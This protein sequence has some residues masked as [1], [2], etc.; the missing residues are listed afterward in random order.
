[1]SFDYAKSAA[2]ASR[3]IERF[4]RTI[5][6]VKVAEGTYDTETS[7]VTNPETLTDVKACD[8]DFEDKSGGQVY[9][10]DSLVQIGDRYC[11]VAPGITAIDTSDKLDIDGVRWNIINVKRLSP[12]GVSVLWTVHIRK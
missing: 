10:S 12:A 11:L 6:H 4:G 2:T 1:M 7:T 3:L 5:Q 9:Q 8:F